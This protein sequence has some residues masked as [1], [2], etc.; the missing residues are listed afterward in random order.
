V[1]RVKVEGVK[2]LQVKLGNVVNALEKEERGKYGKLTAQLMQDVAVFLRDAIRSEARAAGWRKESIRSIF[3]YSDLS[4]EIRSDGRES[5]FSRR[6]R[7][8]LV[9]VRKGAPP[10][11]DP[12][13][14]TEWVASPN[15][16][17]PK[18]E[19]SGGEII[20]MS[21]AAMFEFGT[22]KMPARPA[23]RT[24]YNKVKGQ[25]RLML[26]NRLKTIIESANR[27]AA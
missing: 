10:R 27:E 15:N 22:S 7:T 6:L 12:K 17:S 13:L 24:A 2:A 3:A 9:G 11:F 19:R 1:A 4:R 23:F 26:I 5:Q 21:F 8:S 14:Y 16:K 25:V 18:R 20:G